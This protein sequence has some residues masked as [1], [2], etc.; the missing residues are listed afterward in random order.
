[1]IQT[2]TKRLFSGCDFQWVQLSGL[3]HCIVI[4]STKP[5]STNTLPFDFMLQ[6]YSPSIIRNTRMKIKNEDFM[7]QQCT[8]ITLL[9]IMGHRWNLATNTHIYIRSKLHQNAPVSSISS[10]QRSMRGWPKARLI[11]T[12]QGNWEILFQNNSRQ[13]RTHN[14]YRSFYRSFI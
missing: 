12:H 2:C 10:H 14:Y 6:F 7:S 1:M 8:T 4:K 3:S 11:L 13:N 5:N 9:L